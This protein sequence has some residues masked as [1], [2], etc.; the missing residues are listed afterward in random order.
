[1]LTDG[2]VH[3]FL[4]LA[5]YA[6]S[7][8]GLP[9][10]PWD[11]QLFAQKGGLH[12]NQVQ[13]V[14]WLPEYFNQLRAQL[15][16]AAPP[17]IDTALAGDPNAE[18]LG[19]FV[20]TDADTEL[21]RYRHTCYVPPCYIPLFLTGPLSSRDAWI[22]VKSQFDTDNN[23]VSCSALVDYPRA[24][25]TM[26]TANALPALALAAN[27]TAPLADHEL[28]NHRRRIVELDFPF[29]STTQQSLQQSQIT[30]QLG[31]LIQDSR[32]QQLLEA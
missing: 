30:M 26:S 23:A 19:P 27:P 21:I 11:D 16:V 20:D 18:F 22:I 29:L 2:K 28:M 6:S 7:R 13:T 17:A 14:T 15:R 4:Q 9:A 32:Q 24:A 3:I 8:M 1:M 5:K 31:I 25:I 10:N 12:Q